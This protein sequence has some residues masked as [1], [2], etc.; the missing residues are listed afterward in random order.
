MAK[1][2]PSHAYDREGKIVRYFGQLTHPQL[3]E[4]ARRVCLAQF[5][6]ID[7]DPERI[8]AALIGFARHQ[9]QGKVAP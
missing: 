1:H 9:P 2:V 3:V 8:R 7:V 4:L 5:E 6:T